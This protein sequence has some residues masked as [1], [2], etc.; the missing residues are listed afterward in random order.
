MSVEITGKQFIEWDK[1]L[2]RFIWQG[3]KPRVRFKTLQLPK[4]KGGWALPSL[5]DYYTA[6]LWIANCCDPHYN[7]PWKDMERCTTKNIPVQTILADNKL[8]QY[9]DKLEDPWTKLTLNVWATVIK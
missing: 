1:M 5:K 6:A 9:I 2:S 8:R 3:E 4:D 7:A